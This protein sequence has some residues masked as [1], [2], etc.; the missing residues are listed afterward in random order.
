[1]GPAS[2]PDRR[3]ARA[4]PA[5]SILLLLSLC[6]GGC[7][8]RDHPTAPSAYRLTG[9][10]QLVAYLVDDGGR[11]LGNRVITDASGI[12]VELMDRQNVVAS[13]TT[14]RGQYTFDAVPKGAYRVR[15]RVSADLLPELSDVTVPLTVIDRDIRAG[16]VLSLSSFGDLTPAPNP[17]RGTLFV[18]FQLP[19]RMDVDIRV[20]DLGGRVL[21]H[22]LHATLEKGDQLVG[23]NGRNDTGG[24]MGPGLYW[25]ALRDASGPRVHLILRT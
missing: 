22:V 19:N 11:F 14:V 3:H 2:T 13:T 17:S 1:M 6:T 4:H 18:S 9:A 24:V 10:V 5:L 16:E 15:A 21:Q 12:P 7:F 8:F 23:W 25:F 20:L